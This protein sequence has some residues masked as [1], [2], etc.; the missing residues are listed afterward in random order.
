MSD[1]PLDD[2]SAFAERLRLQLRSRYRGIE[3][4]IDGVAFALT[5]RAA[6]AESTLPLA[7]LH[8]ACLREP[9]RSASL[10]ADFVRRAERQLSPR[11]G[12]EVNPSR[13]LWCVRSQRYLEGLSRAAELVT[14][15]LGASVVAFIAEVLPGSVMRGLAAGDLESAGLDPATAGERASVNT[16]ARF[17]ALPERIRAADRIPA[18][19]WRMS[20]DGLFQGS[21]ITVPEVLAAFAE[22]A[23]GEVLLA[24]PDRSLVLALPASLPSAGRFRMRVVREWREAM[25]PVSRDLL[26][27]DGSSLRE[28][29]SR[30]RRHGFELLGWLRG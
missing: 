4:G 27:T 9:G 13:L 1:A 15:S 19:G 20:S 3:V 24:V 28:V 7:P 12:M 22:R 11:T 18:D 29:E 14:R 8:H 10:I 23:G 21:V 25:N 5:V 26:I 2:R 30:P 6:G 17:A 16:G